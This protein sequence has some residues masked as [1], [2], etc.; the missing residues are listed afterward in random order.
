MCQTFREDIMFITTL[1]CMNKTH[2]TFC[3][4]KELELGMAKEGFLLVQ[5]LPQKGIAAFHNQRHPGN[6]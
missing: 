3:M 4:S 1:K 2:K 5:I 6:H